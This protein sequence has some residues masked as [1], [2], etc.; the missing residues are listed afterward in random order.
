MTE[1]N[2][3]NEEKQPEKPDKND[4]EIIAFI[5]N[6]LKEGASHGFI[7]QK[8]VST[9][10]DIDTATKLVGDIQAEQT[11]VSEAEQLTPALLLT[12]LIG[13]LVA[14]TIGGIIWGLIVILTDY[15][16]GFV[17]IGVGMLSGY[18]VVLFAKNKKGIPLQIIASISSIFGIVLGKF[19]MYHHY[20]KE[21][22][23][24]EYGEEAGADI[25]FL[26]PEVVAYFI[27]DLPVMVGAY[28]LLWVGIAVYVA[29]QIPQ[30]SGFDLGE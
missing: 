4:Q 3:N 22:V 2:N 25:T 12:S 30:K 5:L 19:Y 6:H 9:G 15:E 11:E 17:A 13:A 1:E 16:I 28:D 26:N 20:L 14:S 18:A 27:E 24:E 7:A 29:W 10:M 8:L 23:I 21:N